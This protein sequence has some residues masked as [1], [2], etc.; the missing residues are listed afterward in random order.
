MG[1]IT[2]SGQPGSGKTTLGKMLVK[3][4]NYSFFIQWKK[5][6]GKIALERGITIDELNR[7]GEKESWT[8]KDVDEYQ[9]ELGKKENGMIIEGRLSFYFIPHSTKIYLYS[10]EEIGARRIFLNQRI[11]EQKTESVEELMELLKKW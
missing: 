6:R 7:L 9:R 10:N 5:I 2:I 1:I 8:D 4:L 3:E 11:D